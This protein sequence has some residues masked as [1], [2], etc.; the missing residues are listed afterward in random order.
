MNSSNDYLM[1]D[2]NAFVSKNTLFCQSA[3]NLVGEK[4]MGGEPLKQYFSV[5]ADATEGIN[6]LPLP[7]KK[8]SLGIYNVAREKN[9]LSTPEPKEIQ[10]PELSNSTTVTTVITPS[11]PFIQQNTGNFRNQHQNLKS[12]PLSPVSPKIRVNS[13]CSFID[14]NATLTPSSRNDSST[15]VS[16]LTLNSNSSVVDD[17]SFTQCNYENNSKNTFFNNNNPQLNTQTFFSNINNQRDLNTNDVNQNQSSTIS[18]QTQENLNYVNINGNWK[19]HQQPLHHKKNTCFYDK[20]KQELK[21]LTPLRVEQNL[22]SVSNITPTTI[23]SSSSNIHQSPLINRLLLPKQ[24]N[25]NDIKVS[26]QYPTNCQ[27][28]V[29]LEQPN[30]ANIQVG[31]MNTPSIIYS[32]NNVNNENNNNNNA[33]NYI[34]QVYVQSNSSVQQIVVQ[35]PIQHVIYQP[36]VANDQYASNIMVQQL[37]KP[38][39][40]VIVQSNVPSVAASSVPINSPIERNSIYVP[41]QQQP[42]KSSQQNTIQQV[43]VQLQSIQNSSYQPT[44]TYLS[45]TTTPTLKGSSYEMISMNQGVAPSPS[46]NHQILPKIQPSKNDDIKRKESTT[47]II[48][49]SSSPVLENNKPIEKHTVTINLSDFKPISSH[50]NNFKNNKPAVLKYLPVKNKAIAK[51]KDDIYRVTKNSSHF[52][53]DICQKEFL[54]HFQLKAHLRLHIN[55]KPYKCEYCTRKFC[56]KHDL[57]R[58]VRIHTGDTPYICSNCFKGFARSD[59]C[60]RHVRQNLCK[61]SVISY[62]P[63]T[64]KVEV[65]I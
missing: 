42:Q 55:E 31:S 26:F 56:R 17:Y 37:V 21:Y 58:H 45:T 43:V 12:Y 29:S 11:I 48:T 2:S 7:D 50:I 8:S 34:P 44:S 52:K 19:L 16:S 28:Q 5:L 64:G 25:A 14:S 1:N 63:E 49:P 39:Q 4:K 27:V 65:A 60:T 9:N 61:R 47:T 15:P 38:I 35:Q 62:N 6:I 30:Q 10:I 3:E 40:Q 22:E 32:N 36:T 57:Y 20:R 51:R 23:A 46:L 54:K 24:S 33:V 18:Q 41:V 53:C 13:P 59:A